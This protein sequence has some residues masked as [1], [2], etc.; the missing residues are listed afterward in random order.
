MPGNLLFL[1]AIAMTV[2]GYYR[3]FSKDFTKRDKENYWYLQKTKPVRDF[4]TKK[5]NRLRMKE[6]YHLYTCKQCKQVIRIPRGKEK[7]EI[8]CPKCGNRFIKKS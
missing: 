2:Y 1:L 8:T 6:N 3:A 4:I 5:Y 7:I